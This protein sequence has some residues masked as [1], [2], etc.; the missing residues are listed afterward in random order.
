MKLRSLT[1]ENVRKFAGQKASINGIGDGVTV[2]S[3]ANEFGKSTFFDALHALFF[4]KYGG[5]TREIKALQP[6]SGG[7]VRV[8]AMIE[9]PEGRF[10]VEKTYLAQK[11]ARVLDATGS[12]VALDDEAEAWIAQLMGSGLEGP[13]GLLWVRQGVTALEPSGNVGADKSEKERL[14]GARRNLLSSVAGEID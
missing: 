7:A 6:R 12:V 5:A 11:R 14:L 13:A 4:L 2:V 3:E 8:S 9:L 10:T 1:L